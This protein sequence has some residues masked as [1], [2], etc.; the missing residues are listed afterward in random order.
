MTRGKNLDD[1]R[2][3]ILTAGC[4]D[5]DGKSL[6][7]DGKMPVDARPGAAVSAPFQ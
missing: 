7:T 5:T 4:L 2:A 6:D 1:G 3:L